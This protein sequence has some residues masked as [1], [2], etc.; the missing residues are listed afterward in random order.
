M[1]KD[2]TEKIDLKQK[3]LESKGKGSEPATTYNTS[4][5]VRH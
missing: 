2:K 3:G 1:K 4:K 5:A